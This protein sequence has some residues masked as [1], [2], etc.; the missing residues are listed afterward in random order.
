MPQWQVIGN[1]RYS[2]YKVDGDSGVELLTA[3]CASESGVKGANSNV[4]VNFKVRRPHLYSH[5]RLR[6]GFIV[7]AHKQRKFRAHTLV[8]YIKFLS[9]FQ[10]WERHEKSPSSFSRSFHAVSKLHHKPEVSGR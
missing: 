10:T 5:Q 8:D 4:A 6:R 7:K 1:E 3:E 9:R 2:K